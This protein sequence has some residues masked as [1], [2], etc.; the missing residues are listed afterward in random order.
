MAKIELKIE[1][2]IPM[3]KKT[4]RFERIY[5]DIWKKMNVGDS[6]L[7]THGYQTQLYEALRIYEGCSKG[8]ML[9]KTEGNKMVRVWKTHEGSSN[10]Q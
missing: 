6:I 8:K 1:T 3:P 10:E 9:I 2:D 5:F 7:L 4:N